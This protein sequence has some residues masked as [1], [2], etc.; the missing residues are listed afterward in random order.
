MTWGETMYHAIV[1]VGKV[2]GSQGGG[3]V[4]RKERAIC[5]KYRY[6]YVYLI[7]FFS[8][9]TAR[10][11]TFAQIKSFFERYIYPVAL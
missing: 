9:S 2:P 8:L 10:K 11:H 1:T 7:L 3:W 5:L 6:P 4:L